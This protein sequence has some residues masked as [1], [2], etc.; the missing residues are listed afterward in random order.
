MRASSQHIW[1][2][3][4]WRKPSKPETPA[5]PSSCSTSVHRSCCCRDCHQGGCD[6]ATNTSSLPFVVKEEVAD[7]LAAGQA[8][9]ALESSIIAQG[10]PHP[11]NIETALKVEET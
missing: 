2:A 4:R 8:V 5:P 3:G 10:M 6:M 11:T 1:T 7:A 9:V